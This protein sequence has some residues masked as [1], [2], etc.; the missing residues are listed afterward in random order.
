M[1]LRV[2]LATTAGEART[3]PACREAAVRF[4]DARKTS[5]PERSRRLSLSRKASENLRR[6]GGSVTRVRYLPMG[7]FVEPDF[8]LSTTMRT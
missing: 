1:G 7:Y 5:P 2:R 8:D 3:K 6:R 4:A